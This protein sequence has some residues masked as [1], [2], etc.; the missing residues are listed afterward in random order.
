[1]RPIRVG[2]G[3]PGAPSHSCRGPFCGAGRTWRALSLLGALPAV[4]LCMAN[5]ML[6]QRH[7]R[8]ARPTFVPYHHLRIRTKVGAAVGRTGGCG[9]RGVGVGQKEYGGGT[10]FP[11]GQNTGRPRPRTVIDGVCGA[12]WEGCGR[13]SDAIICG[14]CGADMGRGRHDTLAD[15]IYGADVGQGRPSA[16]VD[17]PN[18]ANM[19]RRR[20]EAE[21]CA[22]DMGQRRHEVGVS[23]IYEADIE[24]YGV[25]KA[26]YHGRWF[27]WGGV[28]GI[29]GADVEQ[30]RPDAVVGG[31]FGADAG[32]R[33]HKVGVGGIYETENA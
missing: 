5:V 26:Q 16:G 32:P 28:V 24:P 27:I 33:S 12:P 31:L 18:G 13:R 25:E 10:V 9:C 2:P 17:E 7:H 22:A 21:T 14:I 19:G 15:G 30:G 8:P 23:G 3:L 11:T 29:C 4:A 20:P 1:M 6:Q